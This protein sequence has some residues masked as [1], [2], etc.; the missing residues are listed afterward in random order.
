M[1]LLINILLKVEIYI[2]LIIA[3]NSLMLG[4]LN[5]W[6]IGNIVYFSVGAFITGYF[7][8]TLSTSGFSLYFLFIIVPII[9]SVISLLFFRI[10]KILK[11][12]FFLFFSI[13]I[14]ELN[15]V[16][17]NILAGPS[18]YSHIKRP[19]LLNSDLSL[20]LLISFLLFLI[21]IWFSRFNKSRLNKVYSV[22]RNN[23][24]LAKSIGINISNKKLPIFIAS[25][26]ISGIA[27]VLFAFYSYG[28]DPTVFSTNE[29]I[30]LFTLIIFSGVD[31]IKGSIIAGFVYVFLS[32]FL[33]S[34]LSDTMQII[35]PK[36]SQII[37]GSL[38]I[39][40]PFVLPKGIFGKRNI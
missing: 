28:A 23:Q 18:G 21:I 9:V 15:F 27:G 39:L 3:L 16:F 14:I 25:S 13:F 5:L 20:L 17:N 10:S 29:I 24:I 34:V 6:S 7:S 36:I 33:N 12:D 37:F 4:K 30:I 32:F 19:E 1:E 8:N 26:I 35:A 2:L 22:I 11:D 31:S 38:L 40:V